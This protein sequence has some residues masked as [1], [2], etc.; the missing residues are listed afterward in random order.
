MQLRARR[1]QRQFVGGRVLTGPPAACHHVGMST[2]TSPLAYRPW[3]A[4]ALSAVV[5]A[6]L[7][8]IV[9]AIVATVAI[10][11]GLDAE[12]SHGLEAFAY[13]PLTIIGAIGA[14]VG[15]HLVNR[16]TPRP[17]RVLRWLVPLALLLSWTPDI[18]VALDT[19]WPNALALMTMHTLTVVIAVLVF[20]W[21]MPLKAA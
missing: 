3:P 15:W 16:Y 19:G 9:N 14:A 21:R 6:V 11:L 20:R 2:P 17:G 8:S 5:V 18:Y 4:I 12:D 7:A 1:A 10:A 13:I